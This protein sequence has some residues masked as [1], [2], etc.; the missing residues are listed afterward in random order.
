MGQILKGVWMVVFLG[1]EP[2]YTMITSLLWLAAPISNLL[3]LMSDEAYKL[4]IVTNH[5]WY[6]WTMAL[7]QVVFIVIDWNLQQGKFPEFMKIPVNISS[8]F[9]TGANIMNYIL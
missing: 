4:N 3:F 2:L 5:M 9:I 6:L 1:F 7:I 8:V